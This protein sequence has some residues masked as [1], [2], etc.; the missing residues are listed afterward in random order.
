MDSNAVLRVA[1]AVAQV[2]RQLSEEERE[3]LESFAAM[4]HLDRWEMLALKDQSTQ[5]VD[6]R[7]AVEAIHEKADREYTL[8]LCF[9]M[10]L[11]GGI[12]PPESDL[13][14][15]IARAWGYGDEVLQSCL[16]EGQALYQ[17]LRSPY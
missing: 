1:L 10:A 8:A 3:L 11:A 4:E 16:R 14:R 7:A 17:R 12:S 13:I 5:K 2:D 15:R 6:L 9:A